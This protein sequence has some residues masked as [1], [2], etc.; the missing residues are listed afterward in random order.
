LNEGDLSAH[1]MLDAG[2]DRT[3]TSAYIEPRATLRKIMAHGT[4]A[5]ISLTY[6]IMFKGRQ[7]DYP[8]LDIGAGVTF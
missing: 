5:E 3:A 7:S 4:F 2:Y 8:G 6:P 1:A